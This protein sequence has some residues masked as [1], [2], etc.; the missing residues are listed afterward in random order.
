MPD[1]K[2]DDDDLAAGP[3]PMPDDPLAETE[4]RVRV[5][6]TETLRSAIRGLLD[7]MTPENSARVLVQIGKTALDG[8]KMLSYFGAHAFPEVERRRRGWMT[9]GEATA[10]IPDNQ[11]RETMGAVVIQQIASMAKD[12]MR[13]RALKEA[14]ENA[15][16]AK[17]A[18]LDDIAMQQGELAKTLSEDLAARPEPDAETLKVGLGAAMSGASSPD[19]YESGGPAYVVGA[20]YGVGDMMEDN[21][22]EIDAE[23]EGA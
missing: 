6:M 7:A 1:F 22:S 5:E 8:R 15:Q 16:L 12:F 21:E 3:E 19:A 4:K 2:V 14:I 23:Y 20:A 9:A 18:G 13:P 10:G 11:T 17:D